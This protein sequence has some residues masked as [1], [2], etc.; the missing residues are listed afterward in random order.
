[1]NNVIQFPG[2]GRMASEVRSPPAPAAVHEQQVFSPEQVEQ[3]TYEDG[4]LYGWASREGRLPAHYWPLEADL[5]DLVA[6]HGI[7]MAAHHL[8]LPVLFVRGWALE[9]GVG[10]PGR[11]SPILDRDLTEPAV[12]GAVSPLADDAFLWS[13][14]PACA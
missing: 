11:V 2:G 14:T 13:G 1:M 8:A 6:Q 10:A 12:A 9:L 3:L 5:K 7:V 4:C